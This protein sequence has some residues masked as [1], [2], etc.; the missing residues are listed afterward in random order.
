MPGTVTLHRV[1]AAPPERVD[2]AF[3][4]AGAFAKWLPRNGCFATVHAMEPKVGGSYKMSFT[5]LTTGNRNSVGCQY[6]E[7]LEGKK[8]QYRRSFD[9]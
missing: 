1:I 7:L 2:Q 9:N 6:G 3:V 4:N 5:N 8:E